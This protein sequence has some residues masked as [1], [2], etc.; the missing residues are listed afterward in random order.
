MT[1]RTEEE[2]TAYRAERWGAT[3]EAVRAMSPGEIFHHFL[4]GAW[5]GP[6]LV[7]RSIRN[8]AETTLFERQTIG[9]EAVLSL[10]PHKRLHLILWGAGPCPEIHSDESE[11]PDDYDDVEPQELWGGAEESVNPVSL[12]AR[13]HSAM[14][15]AGWHSVPCETSERIRHIAEA[16]LLERQTTLFDKVN[17]MAAHERVHLLLW[18]AGPCPKPF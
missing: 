11:N 9:F 2:V 18:G 14:Y 4:Y 13:V 15:G 1:E 5:S 8:I 10:P 16:S 6:C 7:S 12:S 3:I 17:D